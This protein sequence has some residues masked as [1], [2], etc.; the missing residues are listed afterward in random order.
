MVAG[1]RPEVGFLALKALAVKVFA[2]DEVLG[3]GGVRVD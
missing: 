3:E 1:A 2:V